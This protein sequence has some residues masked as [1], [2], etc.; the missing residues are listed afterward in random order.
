L[1]YEGH[2]WS[3]GLDYQPYLQLLN[4]AMLGQSGWE[5]AFRQLHADYLFWGTFEQQ[6]YPGT[7]RAWEHL[8]I[9]SESPWGQIYDLRSLKT[10]TQ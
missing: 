1:G 7:S 9:V 2:L 5:D 8:P 6:N 4:K 10:A 3:H